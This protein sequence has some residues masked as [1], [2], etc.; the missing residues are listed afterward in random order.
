MGNRE[1]FV[2]A[3]DGVD[4]IDQGENLGLWENQVK[5]TVGRLVLLI[6]PTEGEIFEEESAAWIRMKSIP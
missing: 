6:E 2:H 5:T 1:L 3:V 4:L